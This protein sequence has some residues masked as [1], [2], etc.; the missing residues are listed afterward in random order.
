MEKGMVSVIIPIYNVED[1]LA[2]CIESVLSQ[3]YKNYEIIL[4]NDGSTDNSGVI[5][6]EYY[7]KYDNIHLINQSNKGLAESRNVGVSHARG[8]YIY[9]LDSDDKILENLLEKCVDKFKENCI[10]IVFFG[11][12]LF[13][14]NKVLEK[15]LIKGNKNILTG[16]EFFKYSA[17]VMFGM[18][19]PSWS[20]MYKRDFWLKNNIRFKKG[21]IFEDTE[22]Y[23]NIFMKD[24]KVSIIDKCLYIYRVRKESITQRKKYT[25]DYLYS[26][27]KIISTY[28]NYIDKDEEINEVIFKYIKAFYNRKYKILLRLDKLTEEL[29]IREIK[30][31]V[32][33]GNKVELGFEGVYIEKLKEL[34]I[35][36]KF[37]LDCFNEDYIKM[38]IKELEEIRRK[39]ISKIEFNKKNKKIGIYGV[40]YHTEG[41]LKYY[42][43][44]IGKV[45][46]DIIL[47]DSFKENRIDN[48]TGLP[49]INVKDV[50]NYNFDC[51]VLSSIYSEE[52]LLNNLSKYKGKIKRLYDDNNIIL[53][54]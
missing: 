51:I 4:I 13:E 28:C 26:M 20:Y 53:F 5:A 16:K 11:Y 6:K 52:I 37:N 47:I 49:V 32:N 9:F 31:I 41:L 45:E 19:F 22:S 54:G 34:C 50:E 30:D 17:K 36:N 48:V 7:D 15:T 35:K 43:N 42:E 38:K 39:K 46:S 18:N 10:D 3:S 21:L 25:K 29:M 23:I 24:S 2:E 40:G 27:N 14:N 33:I 1:Y 12:I 44:D 8:E